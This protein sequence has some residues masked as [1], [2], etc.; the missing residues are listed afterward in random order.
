M[1]ELYSEVSFPPWEGRVREGY[2]IKIPN[3]S[4][5]LL[6]SRRNSWVSVVPVIP[7]PPSGIIIPA[8]IHDFLFTFVTKSNK[9]SERNKNSLKYSLC[10]SYFCLSSPL[11][12]FLWFSIFSGKILDSL[13]PSVSH[14][15]ILVF[16]LCTSIKNPRKSSEFLLL[17][18]GFMHPYS[19][20]ALA[21]SS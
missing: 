17:V 16:G 11:E 19:A 8:G 1:S 18:P 6:S 4:W 5:F 2:T 15:L 20:Y 7:V 14:F 9:S 12:N 21:V 13:F 10:S 3:I